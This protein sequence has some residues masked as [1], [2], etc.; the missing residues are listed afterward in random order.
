VP[1]PEEDSVEWAIKTAWASLW[2]PRAYEERAYYDIDQLAVGMALLSTPN[3][4]EEEA[5]GVCVTNNIYD[6]SGLEP[7]FI[8][9]VQIEDYEVVQ[10]PLGVLADSYIHYF[11]A[12]GS[13]IVFLQHSTLVDEGETVLTTQQ[14]QDLGI[15]LDAI[16]QYFYPV[17]GTD[18]SWY[19][20]DIEFKFD[21]KLNPGTPE[22]FIKQARP[23]P[24]TPGASSLSTCPS[25]E[26][27]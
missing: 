19:G 10:P 26:T 18:V 1:N 27:P 15:A 11:Y 21:D 8:V 4:P 3:F 24:W 5:N 23:F 6:T 17:Y 7:G 14:S 22:L 12:P 20:M 13:P 9:N 16:H 25:T 2:N